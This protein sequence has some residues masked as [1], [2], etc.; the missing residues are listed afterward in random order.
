MHL[1]WFQ[2]FQFVIW[3]GSFLMIMAYNDVTHAQRDFVNK[4]LF[5]CGSDQPISLETLRN[6]NVNRLKLFGEQKIVLKLI[7]FDSLML[8]WTRNCQNCEIQVLHSSN[9]F[10]FKMVNLI[11]LILLEWFDFY[12][13]MLKDM[14][15]FQF[16]L[17]FNKF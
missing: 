17:M 2:I 9:C 12:I 8:L 4:A 10:N 11:Y 15:N 3:K 5:T 1:I 6:T 7:N 13:C 16:R 14:W